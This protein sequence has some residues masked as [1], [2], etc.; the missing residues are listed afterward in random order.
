M[1]LI[2]QPVID[3]AE[4]LASTKQEHMKMNYIIR[5]ETIREYCDNILKSQ[6]QPRW[7]QQQP[8]RKNQI[9]K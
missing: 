5:L 7:A 8:I 2:P 1:H 4:G 6:N 9:L 3:C